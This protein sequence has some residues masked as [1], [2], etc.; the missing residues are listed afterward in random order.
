VG[1][2]PQSKDPAREFP[3]A[4]AVRPVDA[5]SLAAGRLSMSLWALLTLAMA[6]GAWAAAPVVDSFSASTTVV[7]P[8]GLVTLEVTAHDP[9]CPSTCTTGCGEYLR[10]DLTAWS[11]SG[12][13]FVAENNGTSGSPYV[14]TADWS[15]PAVEGTYTIS[16][17]LADSGSILCGGRQSTTAQLSVLVTTTPNSPPEISLLTADPAQLYPGETSSLTCIASDPDG[18]PLI[19]SWT[20]DIGTVTPGVDGAA[21]FEAGDPGLATVTCTVT[22][23]GGASSSA[24]V[25]ISV[26]SAVAER[27]LTV[28]LVAPQKVSVDSMGDLYVADRSAGGI[29]VIHLFS[30]A[31]VYRL[32][33]PEVSSVAIDW[34]DDVLVGTA[35]G[36]QILDRAGVLLL[37]L[38]PNQ[39]LGPVS[40]VAV[41]PVNHRYAAL[42]QTAGRVVV[43]D[44]SGTPIAAFGSTGDGP[45]QLKSPQGLAFTPTGDLV[46]ADSGHG[47]IKIFDLAGSLLGSFGGLGSGAGE[48][49]RLADVEV[50]ADGVIYA[51]D[52]FQDWVQTFD[53]AGSPREVIGTYGEEIGQFKTATGVLTAE[54]FNRLVVA[55]ANRPSLEVFLLDGESLPPEPLPIPSLSD[56]TLDFGNQAVGSLSNPLTV[57]LSNV[58]AAPLGLR[59]VILDGDFTHTDDCG[60]FLDPGEWCTLAIRFAPTTLGTHTGSMQIDTSAENGLLTVELN[61][62]GVVPPEIIELTPA[63]DHLHFGMV[64]VGSWSDPQ[65]VSVTNTGTV[66][67]A[68]DTVT[69]SGPNPGDFFLDGDLCTG[70]ALGVGQSCDLMVVFAPTVTGDRS[71]EIAIQ[72]AS[73]PIFSVGLSGGSDV[74]FAD[75]F[76]SGNLSR[77]SAFLPSTLITIEP[78]IIDFG[79]QEL[80]SETAT[81]SVT[82]TN[83]SEQAVFLGPLDVVGGGGVAFQLVSDQCSGVWLAEG[84]SCGVVVRLLTLDEGS[85]SVSVEIPVF[86]DNDRTRGY[87]R[88]KGTVLWPQY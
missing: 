59:H 15:A 18:D 6:S 85:F 42:Y 56:T 52:A 24:Q 49:V 27:S 29:T 64:P 47:L 81:R 58:G 1:D 22:D 72:T 46:V 74:L 45:Q 7:A 21:V 62:V 37:D 5:T 14:A 28:G 76:E 9:D 25:G 33:I 66:T 54:A 86:A 67:T 65:T 57:T 75:G 82:V 20:S 4:T 2:I 23:T 61:G 79:R 84:Q 43:Y 39:P 41:D 3:V 26:T 53:Q 80:G 63:P 60:S 48:F 30:G 69:L 88:C 40:D 78:A 11:A 70:T 73:G 31:L 8:G 87:I 34:L 16:V 19:Y 68:I 44:D 71:A 50:G 51:S 10:A 83:R 55:S 35:S 32:P 77:W 12:G 36:A 38:E 13:A 17:Y